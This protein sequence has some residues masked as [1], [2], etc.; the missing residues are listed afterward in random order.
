MSLISKNK[1]GQRSTGTVLNAASAISHSWLM[2]LGVRCACAV[3]VLKSGGLRLQYMR[4][5]LASEVSPYSKKQGQVEV[6]R[7]AQLGT[8]E[9]YL[10]ITAAFQSPI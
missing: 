3:L 7:E 5:N 9:P 10:R 6:A 2:S 1:R 8:Q 4:V